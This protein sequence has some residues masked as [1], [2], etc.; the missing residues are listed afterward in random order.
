MWIFG[1]FQ[2]DSSGRVVL[3]GSNED[4]LQGDGS[5]CGDLTERGAMKTRKYVGNFVAYRIL[6]E[7]R[8]EL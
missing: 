4:A 2:R 1:G 5:K 8:N 3:S 7:D 6:G